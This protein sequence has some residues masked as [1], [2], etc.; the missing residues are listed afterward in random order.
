MAYGE[1]PDQSDWRVAVKDPRD[2]EGEY[3]GAITLKG[4]EFPFHL[5]RL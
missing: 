4:G 1:K 3:L 5:R 2:P